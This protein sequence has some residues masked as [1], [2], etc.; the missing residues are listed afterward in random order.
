M[1]LIHALEQATHGFINGDHVTWDCDLDGEE[2]IFNSA[3]YEIHRA[4]MNQEII[5]LDS[6]C[7]NMVGYKDDAGHT[8]WIDL[9]REFP[10]TLKDTEGGIEDEIQIHDQ[11]LVVDLSR[12]KDPSENWDKLTEIERSRRMYDLVTGVDTVCG[13]VFYVDD[14]DVD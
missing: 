3:D 7:P 13:D 6:N 10:I 12:Y 4:D 2:I 8:F 9:Y 14:E 1:K 5:P 11:L